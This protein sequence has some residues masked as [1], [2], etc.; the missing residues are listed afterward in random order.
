MNNLYMDDIHKPFASYAL[1]NTEY[2]SDESAKEGLQMSGDE[3]THK[4]EQREHEH[5][6]KREKHRDELAKEEPIVL[7]SSETDPEFPAMEEFEVD[8][9]GARGTHNP[10]SGKIWIAIAVI[11][12]VVLCVVF[13]CLGDW[14]TPSQQTQQEQTQEN[15]ETM[16][17]DMGGE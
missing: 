13:A 5:E 2:E 10:S 14:H 9:G 12:I 15:I 3:K 17:M 1:E 11:A 7:E 8:E 6:E 4:R 16:K